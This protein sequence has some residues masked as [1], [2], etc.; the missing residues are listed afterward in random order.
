MCSH[1]AGL[2]QL[3]IGAIVVLKCSIRINVNTATKPEKP[4]H[5]SQSASTQSLVWFNSNINTAQIKDI[6]TNKKQDMMLKYATKGLNAKACC[7][8]FSQFST[9][10]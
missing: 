6:Y 4:K 3:K 7:F 10:I 5:A 9:G 2:V 8:S 1:W